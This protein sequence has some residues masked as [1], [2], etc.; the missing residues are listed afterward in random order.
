MNPT[1]TTPW[2]APQVEINGGRL[3]AE[4]ARVAWRALAL[5]VRPLAE[6]RAREDAMNRKGTA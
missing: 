5:A 3:S 6:A 1:T 4:Q 2:P